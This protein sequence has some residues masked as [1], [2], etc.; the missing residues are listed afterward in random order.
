MNEREPYSGP[1]FNY[2]QN[3]SSLQIINTD[4]LYL[5]IH[6][7]HALENTHTNR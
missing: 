5:H 2:H 1:R 6:I 4:N 3:S 7:Y